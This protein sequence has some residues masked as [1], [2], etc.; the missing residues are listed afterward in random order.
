MN[1]GEAIEAL[2]SGKFVTRKGWNGKGMYLWYMPPTKV[3]AEWCKEPNLKALAEANGGEI[4]CMGS[5]RMKSAD[6]KV[7][8]G[9]VAS[10][11]DMFAEDWMIYVE[12][13]QPII[14]DDWNYRGIRFLRA[15]VCPVAWE[16]AEVNGKEDDDYNPRIPCIKNKR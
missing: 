14:H 16:D 15:D 5:V 1:F 11:A 4:E 8:T 2:K 12:S 9:W 10:Q 3:K 7:V 13:E 6:N